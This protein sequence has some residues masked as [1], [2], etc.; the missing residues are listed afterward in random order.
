MSMKLTITLFI[1]F[2]SFCT[3]IISQTTII[4]Q[5]DFESGTDGWT[6]G[7]TNAV[8]SNSNA[9]S[10]SYDLRV[11]GNTSSSNWISPSFAL[12]TYDKVDFKFFFYAS[13]FDNYEEFYIEYRDISTS[14]WTVIATFRKGDITYTVKTGD[15]D[16]YYFLAKTVTLFKTA[17]TF[18]IAST[19]Q[20]RVRSAPSSTSEYIYFDKV[21]ISGTTYKTPTNGPGGITSN[22]DL[23]LRADKID[24]T[25]VATDGSNVSKWVDNG[26]GNDAEVVVAG[27]EPVYRNSVTRN[28]NFNPVVDF[29]NDNNTSA[30]D[31][32]YIN[33]RDELKGTG[34]FNSNDIFM[35]VMPDPT[36]TTT[37]IPMDTFTS[38]DPTGATYSE[39]VTG[40]GFGSYTQRFDNEYFTYCIG[41][42]T[43]LDNGYGRSDLSGTTNFNKIGIINVRQNV[44]NND[45]ELYLNANKFGTNT[46]D[47][48]DYAQI[49]N[50]RYW[51]GRSQYWSG[52]FDGRIAEV[53]TYS[54]RKDDV[55]ER[56][57][58][59]S[60]L[61]VKYGITLGAN[62]TSQDYVDSTGSIIWDINTGVPANDVF[63][64]DIAGIGR[65]DA[66]LLNQKQSKTV[67]TT[68]DITI[69]L[70]TIS[71]TNSANPNTFG[72]DKEFLVWGNNKGTLAAQTPVVVNM[73][74]GIT[75]ALTT[76]V[77][78]V[79]I[80]RTWKVKETV[81]NLG[82]DDI[83]SCKVSIPTTMLS[84]TLT[85]PGSYLM[86]ISATPNFDPTADYR[87]MT[88]V[89]GNLE[90]NY[91][92][93]GTK[94]I[95]FGFA[96]ETTVIRS[97]Y[98]DGV[99][100]YVDM[101]NALDLNASEFTISAW[102]K[103]DPTS[104]SASILS[105]RDAGFSEGYG[106]ELNSLGKLEMLWI[107]GT[108]QT[109]TSNTVISGNVW[110]QVAVIYK[111]GTASLYIDGVL[112]NTVSLSAPVATTQSFNIAAAGKLTHQ[113]FFK[114]NIDEVRIWD[115]GLTVDQLRYIMNQEIKDNGTFVNGSI[116][117]AAITKNEVATIP[118]SKLAGYYPMSV[119]T[120]TNTNDMSDNGHQGALRNLNTVDRQT[121]PLPYVSDADGAWNTPATWLNNTV[122]DLPNS[123]SIVDLVTPID[124]N[125]VQTA[126]TI[127]S[128]DKDITV[129]GLISTA[130][131][132]TI[133]D[134]VVTSPIEKNDGQELKVTH[135]LE[136]DGVID[137]VGESQL[138][139]TEGC[140]LDIDSGGYIERDQQGTANSFNYNYWSSSVGPISGNTSTRGTGI[141]SVNSNNSVSGALLDGTVSSTP[142]GLNFNASFDAADS[143]PLTPLTISTYWLYTFNGTSDDYYSWNAIDQN[144]PLKPGEGYTMKGTSGPVTITTN[145]NYVFKGKPNNGD[146]KLPII[147]GNDRL[148][149][150]PYASAMDADEFIKDNIK[151]TINSK[152]GRNSANVFNGALYFWHHF[153]E[154]NS[155]NL[156][157]YVGGYATYTLIGGAQAI[158]NDSRIN[159]NLSTGIKVPER[160]IPVNQGFFVHAYL[161]SSISGTTATVDGG[162]IIFKNSQRVFQRE[163]SNSGN[164]SVFFKTNSKNKANIPEK[165][166]DTRS[167]IRLVFNSSNDYHRQL[168]I[169]ADA[170]TSNHF[171]MGY[172][173][174]IADIANDDMFWM[175]DDSKFVI[176]GVPNFN[177]D[178]Q[179]PLGLKIKEQGLITIKID[180]IEN[181][182]ENTAIYI[183]D[184]L[185]GETYNLCKKAFEIN[186]EAGEY[187]N[188]FELTFQQRLKTLKEI[189][190]VDGIYTYMNNN[191]SELHINRIVETAIMNLKLFN[192]LG[193][194][195]EGWA[196]NFKE[197][198]FSIPIKKSAGVYIILITT[199]DGTISKKIIIE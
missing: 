17:S 158:S 49:N 21:T 82:V 123:L 85:P 178:Q 42:T 28:M 77:Q 166:I 195:V 108:S 194:Q 55:T 150:N 189:T 161:P 73:S 50:T 156:K 141:A 39:D 97:I 96:P 23:W 53:I 147:V 9:Y 75:P 61:A 71:A 13:G 177:V 125:I 175:I 113:S 182:D 143:G 94:Y 68:D 88:E 162:D 34:G 164:G 103:R 56:N 115:V 60:Y 100:D 99:K 80:G 168:L 3:S 146:I 46:S 111:S 24:G 191:T 59:E 127:T 154:E 104:V 64:Y 185:T 63:N 90:T 136:L 135:F 19:A 86:F 52:S 18:P 128:G 70:T 184:N 157:E 153:G 54:T 7:G 40:F 124:W 10:G 112:D 106:F 109:I 48:A 193:Q 16:N 35:V 196:G 57:R 126:H 198:N 44:I 119:Y 4:H 107:N 116:L 122:Q 155:H 26:K 45:M 120:Y 65:D 58:I 148:I 183:K 137:L 173:A 199:E 190:L 151:E 8:R 134:P 47:A 144:T 15:F 176:Q 110:H 51:L 69:G 180:T 172:D 38:S 27:E 62:G 14:S 170:N 76:N 22:L 32:S 6:D 78:F 197:R 2:F 138:V 102:I 131:K 91:D 11:G 36:I 114:G 25:T 98:F 89:G 121:A 95:T 41:T 139:Q 188:R 33:T 171:D 117:P 133:A 37:M 181:M 93:D 192:Y 129:L 142:Q 159:N 66:A 12:S 31:M 187:L 130:G 118:W 20:F 105:K 152:V 29:Q 1:L 145:Q 83:T 160:Y 163:I 101:E 179:F 186:L 84:T 149:G 43:G 165:E 30:P 87:I 169:G 74:A 92:F 67:N 5:A 132:L 79:S 174:P 81:V 72:A 140:I 167:K